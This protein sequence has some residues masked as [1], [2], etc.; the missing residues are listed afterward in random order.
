MKKETKIDLGFCVLLFTAAVV[1]PLLLR[2]AFLPLLEPQLFNIWGMYVYWYMYNVLPWFCIAL[3]LVHVFVTKR[4]SGWFVGCEAV[5]LLLG[6]ICMRFCLDPSDPLGKILHYGIKQGFFLMFIL[7]A[8]LLI[9]GIA[10]L[11]IRLIQRRKENDSPSRLAREERRNNQK[12]DLWF[13]LALLAAGVL[14]PL[15]LSV[16][17]KARYPENSLY[18][19]GWVEQLYWY[20]CYM[21]PLLFAA[22]GLVH[23]LLTKRLSW[24]FVGCTEVLTMANGVI[25]KIFQK[26][27]LGLRE[28]LFEGFWLGTLLLY[29]PLLTVLLQGLVLLVMN[30]LDRRNLNRGQAES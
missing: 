16:I 20:Q 14:L 13:M 26:P 19:D 17:L 3:A 12:T 27:E 22:I 30:R 29:I 9:Q 1:I 4:L 6:G 21:L 24:L 28:L 18:P 7:L 5:L 10:L 15:L 25:Y 11:V 23:A 2:F 8:T